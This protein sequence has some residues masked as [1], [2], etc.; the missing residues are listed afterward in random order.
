MKPTNFRRVSRMCALAVALVAIAASAAALAADAPQTEGPKLQIPEPILKGDKVILLYPADHPA[1]GKKLQGY[2]LPENRAM[3]KGPNP[4]VLNVTNVQNPSIEVLLPP[5]EKANGTAIIIAPGGGNKAVWV[6]PEGVD[7]GKW[8]NSLGVAAFVERYRLKPYD[9]ATDALSD[10]QRAI[11]TVRAHASEWGVNPKKIGIM[12]FSAGGE[13]VARAALNFDEG[14]PDASDPVDR[15]SCRPDFAVLVYPGWKELDLNHVPP[16]APPAFC[17]CAGLGDASHAEKTVDFYNAYF[18]A[19][20]PVELHIY[21]RGAHGGGISSRGG[22]PFGT[23][24]YR[25]VDWA[26]DSGILPKN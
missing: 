6:G 26:R 15:E 25:F 14:K 17:V 5:S 9:S 21:A 24:Q 2:D 3:S 7:V 20:I 12:G 4:R 8:L 18:K 23:W 22:I 1:L 19:K 11:R 16:N 13:Q 10:T